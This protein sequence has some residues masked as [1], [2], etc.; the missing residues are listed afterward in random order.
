MP[1][2][3]GL[4]PVNGNT[5]TSVDCGMSVRIQLFCKP[6]IS[7]T[8]LDFK[9]LFSFLFIFFIVLHFL[10]LLVEHKFQHAGRHAF[11]SNK[12]QFCHRKHDET[13]SFGGNTRSPRSSGKFAF[14]KRSYCLQYK[15]PAV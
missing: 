7:T 1:R 15:H 2:I 5:R 12:Q 13:R 11:D 4:I 9:M 14:S 8:D 3:S 10:G 6:Q